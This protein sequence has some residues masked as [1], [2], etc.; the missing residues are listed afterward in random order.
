MKDDSI[1]DKLKTVRKVLKERFG[2]INAIVQPG[3]ISDVNIKI[4]SEEFSNLSYN[5]RRKVVFELIGDCGL[6]LEESFLELLT[7]EENGLFGIELADMKAEDLPFWPESLQRHF[8]NVEFSS[9]NRS[10]IRI[11]LPFI[12]TFYSIKGGVG[13]TTAMAYVAHLLA[14]KDLT[15]VALDFD[16]EA[17]GLSSILGVEDKLSEKRGILEYLRQ[18]EFEEPGDLKQHLIKVDTGKELY[19]FPAGKPGRRYIELLDSLN[20]K[21]YYRLKSNPLH[22]L[23]DDIK[24]AMNPHVILIDART[25]MTSANA[26]LLFDIS[27]MA[28]IF[29]YPA[30]QV[31][32][33]L[34]LLVDGIMSAKTGRGYTPEA[35]FV[36]SPIPA[37]DIKVR[38]VEEL[39]RSF[40]KNI[41]TN[42]YSKQIDKSL[43][44]YDPDEIFEP[45]NYKEEIIYSDAVNMD[46]LP[47][48]KDISSWIENYVV[49]ETPEVIFTGEVKRALLNSIKIDA[50]KAEDIQGKISDIFVKTKDFKKLAKPETILI[51]GGTGSGKTMLFM[52]YYHNGKELGKSVVV[53]APP[54]FRSIKI[55]PDI[56]E[57]MKS[58]STIKNRE[59]W[60]AFWL[61]LM[62]KIL[63]KNHIIETYSIEVGGFVDVEKDIFSA[64]K[65]FPRFQELR[66]TLIFRSN[67]I[68]EPVSYLFDGLDSLFSKNEKT[69]KN[70]EHALTG[71]FDLIRELNEGASN[72]SLK[73]K[74]KNIYFKVFLGEDTWNHLNY[75]HTNFFYGREAVILWTKDDLFR[76]LIKHLSFSNKFLEFIS[77]KLN[78]DITN[79][80]KLSG[81]QIC[82]IMNTVSGKSIGGIRGISTMDWILKKLS[83][84]KGNYSPLNLL[85][86][87]REAFR[88]EKEE[89]GETPDL[90]A[91]ISSKAILKAFK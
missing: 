52:Y 17:P 24:K 86:L 64:F 37:S 78:I 30:K 31:E 2:D 48:Y 81:E 40:I 74:V 33:L 25:G 1:R 39:G 34:E 20:I 88:I 89:H 32:L 68:R 66:D 9:I 90:T 62:I 3:T 50:R 8:E 11:D 36:L 76:V 70:M 16:L 61:F 87:F 65:Y 7:P 4:T 72:P 12:T 19:L 13:R 35:R 44:N 41:F 53:S 22:I 79:V 75:A 18:I 6:D 10:D 84:A 23:F 67:S 49:R 71:L 15:V 60:K 59:M 45:V 73:G 56:M 43:V 46:L 55:L 21:Q 38:K 80:E 29:F 26:P 47:I 63:K 58:D 27:D 77:Q 5:E 54:D 91:L 28:V 82:S 51:K 85:I 42:R 69:Q 83:D 57:F 14:D